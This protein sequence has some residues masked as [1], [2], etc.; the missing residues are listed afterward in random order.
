MAFTAPSPGFSHAELQQRNYALIGLGRFLESAIW[1]LVLVFFSGAIV[2]LTFPSAEALEAGDS[3]LARL[4]WYPIYGIVAGMTLMNFAKV[5]R[6]VSRNPL[7]I[8]CV[9]WLGLTFFWSIDPGVTMRRSIGLLMTTMAGLAFAARYD[10]G[11]MVQHI[12][13]AVLILCLITLMLVLLNPTRGIMQEIYPGAW[14]GPWAEKN[15]LGG[16]MAKGFAVMLCAFAMRPKRIWIWGPTAMLCLFMMLMSGSKTALLAMMG[17]FGIFLVVRVFRRFPFLRVP[18]IWAVIAGTAGLAL[19]MTVGLEWALGL[20]GK[21]PTLTGRTDI[22][23]LLAM[24]IQDKF[25]LGYG[26]GT[27]W[28]DPLGPSYQTREVLQWSVPT[29][30]NGWLDSWLSGGAVIIILFGLLTLMT[31]IKS[32]TRIKTGGVETYWVVL[33]LFFFLLFSISE[34]AILQ[35]NDISWFLF[36]ATTAKLWANDPAWWRPGSRGERRGT[37]ARVGIHRAPGQRSL[38]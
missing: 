35:Q 17:C 24:A 28:M 37:V 20:I 14:R 19:I 18:V 5:L 15:Y 34:S 12:G 27:F 26:Y 6:L 32:L 10:W 4:L 7:I 36:T 3:P 22:W 31:A 33:S 1:V 9:L 23:Q 11:E 16:I 25:W 2:G 13:A 38:Y 30:H 29:A 21:D 8:M